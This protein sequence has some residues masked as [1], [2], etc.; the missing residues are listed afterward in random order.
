MIRPHLGASAAL[1]CLLAT[2][3]QVLALGA[4]DSELDQAL[5]GFDEPEQDSDL[6]AAL[7]GFDN[8]SG[9]THAPTDTQPLSGDHWRLSG[10]LWLSGAW[11]YAHSRPDPGETDWRGLSQLRVNARPELLF[12]LGAGWDANI[13]VNAFYDFAYSINGR[14]D[15]TSQ[16]LRE[17]ESELELQDTFVRGSLNDWLDLKLG[18][19]IV[20]WGKSDNLRVV[21]VLNPLDQRQPGV[22][23]IENLRLPVT[24]SRLDAYRGDWSLSALV[25]HEIRF[26]KLP[27][28]GSEFYPWSMPL[29]DEDVPDDGGSN[30]EYALALSGIM[31]G[32]DISFHLARLFDDTAHLEIGDNRVKRVHSRLHMAGFATNAVLGNW[33]LKSEIAHLDGLEFAPA[34]GE[35]FARTDALLGVDYNGFDNAT[36]TLESAIRHLHD[37]DPKL[38]QGQ[39]PVERNRVETAFRYSADFYHERWNVVLVA[40]RYGESLDEGGI[41]RAQFTYEL[42]QALELTA[43]VVAYHSADQLPFQAISNNDRIFAEL[44]FSF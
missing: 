20:V 17:Y 28:L 7:E 21:D 4:A 44:R 13:R 11:N 15:Y 41:T 31:P 2:N 25:L 34:P 3:L 29:P 43:G 35:T 10:D 19:Q 36:L 12:D 8:P 39:L 18:R 1:I 37:Y 42:R 24:M 6:D 23:D 9:D 27:V 30:T 26:D 32:W 38:K 33:L 40:T 22:T 5:S 16:V 14:S